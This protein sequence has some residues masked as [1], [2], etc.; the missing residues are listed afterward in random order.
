MSKRRRTSAGFAAARPIDKQLISISLDDI[1]ATQKSTVLLAPSS[2]CTVLEI[3]WSLY[4]EGDAGSV[5]SEHDYRWAI[6]QL[7]DGQ[8]ANTI[9]GTDAGPFY[10]PE[11][12][13]L[14]FGVRTNRLSS[15]ATTGMTEPHIWNGK[16]KSMRKLR[17][18]DRVI[19]ICKGVATETSRVRGAV[20]LFCKS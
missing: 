12:H 19:F 18:G 13:C 8:T 4:V 2:A 15:S 9:Q 10:E 3:R 17:V 5:G 11:Q 20:Q 6:I 7:L 14:A 1:T 16:T